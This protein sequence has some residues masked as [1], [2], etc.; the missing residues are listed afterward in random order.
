MQVLKASVRRCGADNWSRLADKIRSD[1]E[2]VTFQL[3]KPQ[4]RKLDSKRTWLSSVDVDVALK[5]F[6]MSESLDIE[7]LLTI[8]INEAE[9]LVGKPADTSGR[10]SMSL[11]QSDSL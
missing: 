4:P 11:K 2:G 1:R 3:L 10:F 7:A 9:A 5:A 8:W 6:P